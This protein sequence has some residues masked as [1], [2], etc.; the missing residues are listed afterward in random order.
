MSGPG[1]ALKRDVK[2]QK[3]VSAAGLYDVAID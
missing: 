1:G 3:E 2:L